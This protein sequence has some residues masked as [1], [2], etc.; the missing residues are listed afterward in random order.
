MLLLEAEVPPWVMYP[1]IGH[2]LQM[3]CILMPQKTI[4]LILKSFANKESRSNHV[5]TEWMLQS[6]VLNLALE[7]LC[8]KPEIDRDAQIGKQAAFRSDPG[9]MYIDSFSRLIGLI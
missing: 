4:L 1:Q 2:G 9:E 8:F 3:R 6:T 7:H 5:G